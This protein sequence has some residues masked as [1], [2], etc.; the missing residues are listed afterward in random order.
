MELGGS[1]VELGQ[2]LSLKTREGKPEFDLLE[3]GDVHE[4]EG[5]VVAP[6]VISADWLTGRTRLH[7]HFVV[8]LF[9]EREVFLVTL[10]EAEDVKVGV[11]RGGLT[12]Q[13]CGGPRV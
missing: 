4:A 11:D 3:H 1:Y 6:L 10:L 2:E 12:Q 5:S 9:A 13:G 8:M 7:H